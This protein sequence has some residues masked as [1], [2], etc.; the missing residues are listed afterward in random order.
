MHPSTELPVRWRGGQSETVV[1][2]V[3]AERAAQDGGRRRE[4][5]SGGGAQ[6]WWRPPRRRCGQCAEATVCVT[7]GWAE[8]GG[9]DLGRCA[10]TR[11]AA[12]DGGD[13]A[14]WQRL[15][16]RQGGQSEATGGDEKRSEAKRREEQ[17]THPPTHTPML[18][19]P[20]Y[21]PSSFHNSKLRFGGRVTAALVPS[22]Y[23]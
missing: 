18:H 15:V 16:R 7:V 14:K 5:K 20:P 8:R 9:G 11:R 17:R 19:T 4:E 3:A 23:T 1:A 6:W 13:R 10:M 2:F 21:T 12:R 22:D